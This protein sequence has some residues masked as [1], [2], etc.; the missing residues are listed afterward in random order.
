[1]IQ[2]CF[3][4]SALRQSSVCTFKALLPLQKES[5]NTF[6]THSLMVSVFNINYNH[7]PHLLIHICLY[8]KC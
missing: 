5:V 7:A 6:L 8:E 1:M 2:E 3:L 4:S